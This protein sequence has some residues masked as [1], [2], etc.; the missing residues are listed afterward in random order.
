M[1]VASCAAITSYPVSGHL[2]FASARTDRVLASVRT[3][4]AVLDRT[5]RQAAGSRVGAAPS[6]LA[7]FKNSL[8]RAFQNITV[9]Y[10]VMNTLPATVVL[11]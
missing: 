10:V 2:L 3:S 11:L 1:S 4:T 5:L 7:R 9:S 8:N 6:L